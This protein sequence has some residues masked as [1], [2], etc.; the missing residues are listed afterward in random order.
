MTDTKVE[1]KTAVMIDG[2]YGVY[3]PQMF[4]S[5]Y[6]EDQRWI[7]AS[8][9]DVN[10]LVSGPDHPEYWEAWEHVLDKAHYMDKDGRDWKL[11]QEGDLFAY[12]GDGEQ[13][14]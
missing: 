12:T 13:W 7:G 14:T 5:S 1:E 11:W 2:Q 3:I 10:N 4:A 9:D 6:L 8:L